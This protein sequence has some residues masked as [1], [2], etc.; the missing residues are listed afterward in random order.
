[1]KK[2]NLKC[3]IILLMVVVFNNAYAQLPAFMGCNENI[4][5]G[6]NFYSPSDTA[7]S[8]FIIDTSQLNNIWQI[9]RSNKSALGIYNGLITDTINSYPINNKSSFMVGVVTCWGIEKNIDSYWGTEI[10]INYSI[11]SDYHKDG[12]VLETSSNSRKNWRN[13]LLDTNIYTYSPN[14]DTAMY[15]ISDTLLSAA[16]PGFSGSKKDVF[17]SL[18]LDPPNRTALDTT[19]FR[20]T[21]YSD[22]IQTN[23]AGF[24]LALFTIFP[25]FEGINS[26]FSKQELEINPNPS[27]GIIVIKNLPQ[28]KYSDVEIY[29]IHGKLLQ[30]FTLLE[31]GQIDISSFE[32]G[33]YLL[34]SGNKQKRI[35]KY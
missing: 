24:N 19:W 28:Q 4:S 14:W 18:M 8:Y 11:Q 32:S 23:K 2:A 34:K 25:V 22:S 12:V 7:N 13:I 9:G 27:N 21:F 29:S 3:I 20:F 35:V 33:I 1:M 10:T 26:K 6:S 15:T 30:K 17:L 31:N 5:P 16:Q